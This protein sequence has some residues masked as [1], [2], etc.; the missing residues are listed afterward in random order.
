[1]VR[2]KDWSKGRV[3]L[4]G[5]AA[6]GQ[7]PFL[8]QG[9]GCAMM[10]GFSLAEAINCERDVIAGIANWKRSERQL[11]E[12]VQRVAYWYGQLALLPPAARNAAFK[13]IESSEALKR[14]TLFA[15]ARHDPTAADYWRAEPD[16]G[17]HYMFPLVH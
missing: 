3:A 12:W 16:L 2:V 10:S 14:A 7:P 5:D 13:A 11:I 4:V 1:L 15:G 17:Y 9:G 6:S 8:G